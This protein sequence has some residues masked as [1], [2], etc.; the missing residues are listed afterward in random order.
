MNFPQKRQT[1]T[2]I[3]SASLLLL[4]LF[5]A[6]LSAGAVT[7]VWD[8]NIEDDLAGY[9]VYYGIGSR[10]YDSFIDVGNITSCTVTDLE[11][12]T[13]YY[14]AITAYDT[15]LN[16]SD[17]SGEVSA[18]TSNELAVDF[19][20]MGLWQYDGSTW[21][22]LTPSDPQHL[23][24]Y[25]GKLVGDF[26]N[27]GLWEFDGSSW[28]QLTS[29]D[30]DDD[31]NYMVAWGTSLAIDLGGIGL[32]EYDGSTWSRLTSSNPEYLAVYDTKLVGDFGV[33]GLWEFDGTSWSKLTPSDA[34]NSG[35]CMVTVD[36]Q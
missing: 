18:I 26:G 36:S 25:D 7:L 17:F 32:W 19:G 28:T 5:P 15:S 24:I 4:A 23:A 2:D 29:S 22:S 20:S 6:H 34:D 35:N 13:Q 21:N 31:G 1:I 33:D 3:V 12:E 11:P 27:T 10:V 9:N 30:A 16:E 14:F 8:P